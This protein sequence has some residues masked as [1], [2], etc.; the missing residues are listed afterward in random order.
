MNLLH[1]SKAK[2]NSLKQK[3]QQSSRKQHSNKYYPPT[4][5][6]LQKQSSKI[7]N[8]TE[9]SIELDIEPLPNSIQG[10]TQTLTQPD[11]PFKNLTNIWKE[12][13]TAPFKNL[14]N[15][16]KEVTT[17]PSNNIIN[18]ENNNVITVN[19]TSGI[20]MNKQEC[21][22]WKGPIPLEQYKINQDSDPVII[23]KQRTTTD[24]SQ[25]VSVRFLKPP[26]LLD[27]GDLI[28]K[29]E[30]PQ[31]LPSA[32]PIIIRQ[33]VESNSKVAMIT[34]APRVIREKPPRPPKPVPSQTITIPGKVLDPPARQVIIERVPATDMFHPQDIIIE[35]WL[36][37]PRQIRN[38]V[39]DPCVNQNMASKYET[40]QN[41]II[42]WDFIEENEQVNFLGVETMDPNEYAQKHLSE[43][44][45]SHLIPE[46]SAEIDVGPEKELLAANMAKRNES[47]EFIYT[48]D[49]QALQLIDK[50]HDDL[51]KYLHA[52]L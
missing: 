11:L 41:L 35:R 45:E 30:E 37:Y 44:V 52:K 3:W 15:I 18:S 20:W 50:N 1:N 16:W 48:G 28:L 24:V 40:P 25:R 21:Q 5:L 43:L 12:A 27:A 42:D 29:E 4:H 39:Y 38:V 7:F 2:L 14:T 33:L 46:L 10:Q 19:G 26:S 31:Q 13:T 49:L 8:D 34:Q 9:P 23:R 51:N 22:A 36:S 6:Y 32:P 17:A 47:D